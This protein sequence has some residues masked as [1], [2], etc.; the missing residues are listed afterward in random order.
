MLLSS[1]T[2]QWVSNVKM[3]AIVVDVAFTPGYIWTLSLEGDVCVWDLETKL[4]KNRFKDEGCIKGSRIS[5]SPDYEFIA[6]GSSSGIVNLYK[7]DSVLA[8]QDPKPEKSIMNLTTSI[9]T[10]E[11]HPSS[12]MLA[13]ASKDLKDSMRLFH[14]PSKRVIQNWPTGKTPL[15][16][17]SAVS[18]SPNGQFIAI[19]NDKGKILLYKFEDFAN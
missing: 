6:I 14:I 16:Y 18:F 11:F 5:I 4:C 8:N 19:G 3:N 10:I 12:K 1:K 13:I 15:G 9:T 17:V 2:K 7:T